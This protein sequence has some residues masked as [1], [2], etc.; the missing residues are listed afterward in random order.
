MINVDLGDGVIRQLPECDLDGP[1]YHIIDNAH[2][3][4]VATEYHLDG[5]TVHR[6]VHVTLKEGLGIE[7]LMGQ[8][9]GQ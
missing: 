8:F 4:T 6:S 5:R 9:N 3:R 7:A 1:F 2:E